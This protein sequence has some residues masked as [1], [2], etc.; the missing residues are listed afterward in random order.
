MFLYCLFV[1]SQAFITLAWSAES[2]RSSAAAYDDKSILD[3]RFGDMIGLVVKYSQGQPMTDLEMLPELGVHWVRES[4]HWPVIE[5]VAGQYK[6]F[7]PAFKERLKF[8]NRHNIGLVF[9]LA[10]ENELA[11]PATKDDPYRPVDPVAF[12]RYAVQVARML[13]SLDTNF[14]LEV[15]NEPHNFDLRKRLSGAWNGFPPS[16]WVDHYVKMVAETVK[17][18]KEF[19][20]SIKLLSDDDMWVLH[21]RFLDAGLPTALDGFAFHPYTKIEPEITA[22]DAYTAWV[23][24]YTVVDEDRSFKSAVNRLREYGRLKLGKPP[25]MW[26]TEWGWPIGTDTDKGQV[27]E[28]QS[29]AYLTRAFI[30]AASAGVDVLCWFSAQDSVDGPM[31]LSDNSGRRRMSFYAFKTM[32]EQL[33]DL[34]LEKH[35]FGTERPTT[36]IQVFEFRG[37]DDYTLV[38]WN[39]ENSMRMLE[40]EFSISNAKITDVFGNQVDLESTEMGRSYVHL[41]GA[42]IY[43]SGLNRDQVLGVLRSLPN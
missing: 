27:D 9:I 43:L 34:V 18:V 24:P 33:G 28:V 35:V 14:V 25:E 22:V 37:K 17:Q 19:D 31:G 6:E 40:L 30:I 2:N 15:W 42:P 7:T 1:L 20:P 8:Y 21:Y 12:G 38:L 29:G 41:S 26:I 5:P 36:G 23:K 39:V 10:Y 16:P 32:S 3:R 4:V 11:Y 13:K